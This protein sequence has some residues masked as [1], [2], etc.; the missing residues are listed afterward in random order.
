MTKYDKII[1][2]KDMSKIENKSKTIYIF[3]I[4]IWRIL[5]YFIIYSV[6]GFFI[7]TIYGF[8]TKGVI[9]SRQGFLYGPFCPIYGVGAVV[10]IVSLQYFKKNI[11]T[12]FFGGFLVGSIVEYLV[13]FFGELIF[14]MN[15]WDYSDRFLNINGR[16]CVTFSL[17]WGVL[18]IYLL[19]HFNPMIDK[20]IDKIKTKVSLNTLKAILA[21]AFALLMLDFTMTGLALKVFFARTVCTYDLE[22]AKKE[23]YVLEYNNLMK[24][25]TL[26]KTTNYLFTDEKMLKTFPNLKLKSSNGE[27]IYLNAILSHIQPY[28]FKFFN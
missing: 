6:L 4:S 9:E 15:W 2:V 19:K 21:I 16:I 14:N 8:L 12:I 27:I 10:M 11:Y 24:N 28:Y 20:I 1:L 25:E 26:A 13:S 18:A 5:A 23:K 3:G 17:F 22:I 7:E